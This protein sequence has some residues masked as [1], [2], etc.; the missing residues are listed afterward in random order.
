MIKNE[1]QIIN[2]YE[3]KKT[4]ET[5]SSLLVLLGFTRL[6]TLDFAMIF[7]DF[8][9]AVVILEF[10]VNKTLFPG[11]FS[12]LSSIFCI[13][14]HCFFITKIIFQ[15]M[16]NKTMITAYNIVVI[17]IYFYGILIHLLSGIFV[18]FAL[19]NKK[20]DL[21]DIKKEPPEIIK[22]SKENNDINEQKEKTPIIL[23]GTNESESLL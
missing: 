6:I 18:I 20:N 5:L 3:S 7:T 16:E 17:F 14:S 10:S 1:D 13:A 11:L 21:S 15:M 8:F 4:Y 23:D 22:D 2:Y 9:A 12:L 19:F